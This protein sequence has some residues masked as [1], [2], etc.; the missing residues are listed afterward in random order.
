MAG[1]LLPHVHRSGVQKFA[2]GL[3]TAA[4][5]PWLRLVNVTLHPPGTSLLRT[6][7]GH[8]G[9]VND[10]TL[11]RDG[12]R[13]L[14]C[15]WDNTVKVWDLESGRELLS[16]TG[17]TA[18]VS[19]VVVTPDGTMAVSASEDDTLKIWDL[20]SGREVATLIGQLGVSEGRGHYGR[21]SPYR[22]CIMGP[23]ASG[24]GFGVPTRTAHTQ[25]S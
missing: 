22:F 1:R 14:S 15:S 9:S 2:A 4:L 16:L 5:R 23:D 7:D 18:S 10:V 8:S 17:H 25:G 11:T 13:A 12:L 19:A 20:E 3:T 21:W 6:L 24:V